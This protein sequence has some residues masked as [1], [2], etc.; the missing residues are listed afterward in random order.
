MLAQDQRLTLRLIAEKLGNSKDTAHTIVRDDLGKRKIWSRFVPLRLT[1]EQKAKRIVTPGD[2]ISMCVN[3]IHCFRKT[4]SREMRPVVTS[5]NRNQNGNW[6][7]GFHRLHRDQ[8]RVVCKNPNHCWSPSSTIKASSIRNLF[9]L[10]K[11]LMPNF[12]RQVWTDFYSVSNG[13]VQS[14][15]GLENVCCSTIIPLHIVRSVCT[16]SWLR[17]W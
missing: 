7:R 3:R 2:F 15:I 17:R 5:S 6:W 9:L 8:K 12:T 14:C 11:I 13:F 1:D 10:V 16:N 4:S